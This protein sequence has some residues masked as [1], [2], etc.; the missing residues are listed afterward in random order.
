MQSRDRSL[1]QYALLNLAILQADFGCFSEAIT[2][3]QET[4]ATAREN[5]DMPCLN[6][7]LSW[8]YQFGRTHP[9]EMAEIQKKGV[10]GSEKE[11]LSFLKAKAKESNMWTLLSTTLLSEAKL[12][13]SNVRASLCSRQYTKSTRGI[14]CIKRLKALSRHPTLTSRRISRKGTAA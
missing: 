2:A 4:I 5:H 12:T 9:E 6:Y 14:M 13:L 8:L 10:L 7:S 11:A 1:Y 3:M